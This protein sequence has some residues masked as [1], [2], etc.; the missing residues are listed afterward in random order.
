MKIVGSPDELAK[1]FREIENKP[2]VRTVAQQLNERVTRQCK[3]DAY[4]GLKVSFATRDDGENITTGL[5]DALT[6]LTLKEWNAIRPIVDARFSSATQ[7]LYDELQEKLDPMT[8][9]VTGSEI[10]EGTKAWLG[11]SATCDSEKESR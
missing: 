8:C 11:R 6:K 3:Q 5:C 1:F 9:G 10:Y 7:L 4:R 2:D